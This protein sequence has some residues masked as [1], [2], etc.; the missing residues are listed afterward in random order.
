MKFSYQ[1][2][3]EFVPGLR[4][5]ARDLEQRITL[6]TAECEGIEQVGELL[7]GA[8]LARV[9]TA[10]P[11]SGTHITKATVDIGEAQPVT[12]VCGAPN[13]RAGMQ[14]VWI[15]LGRKTIQ[16]IE[17]NGMLASPQELGLG[18]DHAGIIEWNGETLNL[19]PDQII[20]IDNKS[21]THR[22]DLWG[23]LGMAREV[24]AITKQD[25]RDPVDVS[26]LPGGSD[27]FD[28]RV[29]DYELCPRFSVIVFE[30]VRVG[31]SPL[32][33][34]Y[35]LMSVGL[36]PI[37]NIVDIT[38]Y[39]MAELAQPMHA[40]DR[41][42]LRGDR[43]IIRP[44]REGEKLVAL[45]DEE[46]T[47]SPAHG[48]VADRDGAVSIAGVIGGR[49]SAISEETTNIVF[50]SA[51]WKASSI[52][53]TSAALK[54]RTDASM[55]FEKAQDPANTVRALARAIALMKLVNPE[56]RLIGRL[57]D[58]YR[59]LPKQPEIDLK[60]DALNRKLGRDVAPDE[61]QEI[62]ERLAFRVTRPQDGVF[63]VTI[64]SWRATKDVNVADDLVEEVG[65]M[66]GYHTI[67]PAPP[68]IAATVPPDAPERQ[69]IRDLKALIAARGFTEVYNYSFLSDEQA[70]RFGLPP[71]DQVRV[72]NPI[73]SDQNL[74][75][76]SLIPGIHANVELNRKNFSD[77]R[78]FEIGREIHRRPEGLPAEAT[79]L[80][81]AIYE[82]EGDGVRG[83][84]QLKRLAEAIAPGISAEPTA[85]V[86]GFEHPARTA[87]LSL[88]GQV[89]GRLF[90]FHPDFVEG[91]AAVVD[92]DLD[93]LLP[94]RARPRQY[95]PIHRFP[96]SAFDL[97][98][99][100]P[101][102]EL[103]SNLERAIRAHAG[104]LLEIIEYLYEYAGP[105]VPKGK[106]S[107]SF[108]LKIGAPDR[109]L[110]NDE[111]SSVRARLIE[112]LRGLG[113]E[114]RV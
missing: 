88:D 32:W 39:V 100:A 97:S 113:Y 70:S 67:E 72:L 91:R 57:T 58:D 69:S 62:L 49:D 77:F 43:L 45:D 60:L 17:S 87:A 78:L 71:A 86:R 85:D 90:E 80:V 3:R 101:R 41:D 63:S 53:K 81:A 52:R 93:A 103:T 55:R 20:E 38:N 108:R 106:K 99:L 74:M 102:R 15:P 61:V 112:A 75:R 42:K 64:P 47:L 95:A 9:L 1:W 27:S 76:S 89:V 98:V 19:E 83:L 34:Q 23:H 104:E 18:R 92:V 59:S 11:V 22:P 110:S 24:A 28:V 40:F 8:R 30:N 16:G 37:N 68:L 105:N 21:L 14:T 7:N 51:N 10:E 48:V 44:A 96:S 109:T 114:M 2:I 26:L 33:L 107:V 4:V 82:S 65:R 36:N 54:L 25:L 79:H 6:H 12:V 56:A 111:I 84:L 5:N 29:E 35:R 46:Y 50:E 13:C 66:I 94:L 31:P 73:A